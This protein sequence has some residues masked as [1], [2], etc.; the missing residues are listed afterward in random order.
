[1][2][3]QA[4]DMSSSSHWKSRIDSPRNAQPSTDAKT[5]TLYLPLREWQGRLGGDYWQLEK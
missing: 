3:G 2:L 5:F 1:M 4:I